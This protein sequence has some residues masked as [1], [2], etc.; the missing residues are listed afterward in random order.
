MRFQQI[1]HMLAHVRALH[2]QLSQY[3][4]QLSD[5]TAQGRIKLLVDYIA[6]HEKHLEASLSA[7]EQ[8]APAGVLDTWVDCLYCDEIL[9]KCGETPITPTMTVDG[10]TK[11]ATKADEC[12]IRFYHSV[13]E[14]AESESVRAAFKNLV[15]LESSELRRVACNIASASEM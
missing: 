11:V 3:Y 7:Y 6:S 8:D 12:L 10:V 5:K 9:Q 15:E 2:G 14:S 13:A 1:S 4:G